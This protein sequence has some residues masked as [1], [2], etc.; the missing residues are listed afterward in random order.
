MLAVP[1]LKVF[2]HPPIRRPSNY[3]KFLRSLR[4]SGSGCTGYMFQG[5]MEADVTDSR[6]FCPQLMI[7]TLIST[8]FFQIVNLSQFLQ[9]VWFRLK[10]LLCSVFF[11]SW[12]F[13]PLFTPDPQPS[14]FNPAWLLILF[15]SGFFF[16][17]LNNWTLNQR[18]I[19][20]EGDQA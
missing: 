10:I 4:N 6:V 13:L 12:F 3:R 20:P 5:Q 16:F 15:S 9:G 8:I 2:V 14:V 11:T 7:H 17:L 18:Q 1:F 19:Y